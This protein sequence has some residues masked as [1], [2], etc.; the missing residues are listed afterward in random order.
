MAASTARPT[1]GLSRRTLLLGGVVLATVGGGVVS[2]ALAPTVLRAPRTP[3]QV[4]T[5]QAFS[6]VAALADR[7]CPGAAGLP[8]AWDL[9]VPEQVDAYLAT[10]DPRTAGELVLGLRLL[11]SGLIGLVLDGRRRTFTA[12]SGPEQD[13]VLHAW[14]TSRLAPR[15]QAYAGL[16]RLLKSVYWARPEVWR[17]VGYEG[18][19]RFPT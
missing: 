6:V 8:S 10:V 15:K 19:P 7:V 2:V 16:L 13:S 9:G 5:P 14:R 17:H 1:K 3:L 4:L 18:P 11:E 12:L